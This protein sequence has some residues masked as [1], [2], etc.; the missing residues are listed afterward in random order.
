MYGFAFRVPG[1]IFIYSTDPLS[2]RP[3]LKAKI[4][5]DKNR[6]PS[7]PRRI[8]SVI[9]IALMRTC[10]QL[11]AEC[12]GVLYGNVFQLYMS[13][14]PFAPFYRDLVRHIT[15]TTDAD[16]R[17]FVDD[18]ETVGYWWRKR[19]WPDIIEKSTK[20]LDRYPSL[21][22]LTFPIRLNRGG[23]TWRP[24]FLASDMKTREQRI[25]LAASWMA[26]KCPF[27]NEQLR[28]CLHLEIASGLSKEA[29]KGSTFAPEDD[30]WDAEEFAEAFE[31]MKAM[32]TISSPPRSDRIMNSV[33]YGLSQLATTI[34]AIQN[35]GNRQQ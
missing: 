32:S 22:T 10:R 16:H 19:F 3:I 11:H 33:G 34:L 25:A 5:K 23:Q 1:A 28:Q 18:L 9:P 15:F 24:A 13:D 4:V 7:E 30:E 26:A 20:M 17:I 29:Y 14:A 27:E 8:A 35:A 12:R 2:H 31:R 6:G 21:E